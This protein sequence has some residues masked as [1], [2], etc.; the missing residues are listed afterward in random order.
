MGKELEQAEKGATLKAGTL[1]ENPCA[2]HRSFLLVPGWYVFL[3]G[4]FASKEGTT[5]K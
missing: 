2:D 5:P 1:R 4:D 3:G